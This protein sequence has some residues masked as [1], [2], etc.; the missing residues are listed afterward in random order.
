MEI[1]EICKQAIRNKK[2]GNFSASDSSDAIRKALLEMNGG[3]TK[4]NIKT[5][6]RGTPMFSLVEELLPEIIN[7][8]IANNTE[9]SALVDYRNIA[10]GDQNE[11][12]LP[13]GSHFIV[14]DTAAGIYGVRRQKIADRQTVSVPTKVKFVR[15]YDDLERFLA[16]R[17]D[18]AELIDMISSDFIRQVY[19]D[20]YVCL[21][22][23]TANTT[24][25]SS[26]YVIGGTFNE[27]NLRTL[28]A[29]VE[30]ENP[31]KQV[32]IIGTK[33][34]LSKIKTASSDASNAKND[35]YDLGYYGRFYGT[36]MV[37]MANA[38]K[39]DGKTF[40]L[41][42]SKIFIVAST[43]KPLKVVNEGDGVMFE[44]QASDNADA[45][46]EFSYGQAVGV[47]FAPSTK[48]GICNIG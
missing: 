40:V 45:T 10:D 3:S 8:G 41:S 13:A 43:D 2:L 39:A 22:N 26:E 6:H 23:V 25:M 15:V 1:V 7:D 12:I 31:G 44:K 30:A 5:F 20:A 16:G 37:W 47:A 38:H 19:E 17:V 36:D 42:D 18:F 34:A 46:Q 35:L 9:L 24:G 14:R 28:I 27:D 4:V 33:I 32:K 11:F 48:M 21:S 29:H